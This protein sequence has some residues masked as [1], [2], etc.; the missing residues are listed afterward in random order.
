MHTLGLPCCRACVLTASAYLISVH[1]VSLLYIYGARVYTAAND[2]NKGFLEWVLAATGWSPLRI[3]AAAR[4]WPAYKWMLRTGR[5]QVPRTCAGRNLIISACSANPYSNDGAGNVEPIPVCPK[6]LL[7]SHHYYHPLLARACRPRTLASNACLL[8]F[9][10][11]PGC[12]RAC[13]HVL[14]SCGCPT[15][16]RH[17]R[18]STGGQL[19]NWLPCVKG[20]MRGWLIGVHSINADLPLPLGR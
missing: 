16:V 6:V 5:C 20:G 12:M 9:I 19:S 7:G 13:M 4:V 17:S 3:A 2:K 14:V 15:R 1:M 11:T 8:A 10:R 18:D